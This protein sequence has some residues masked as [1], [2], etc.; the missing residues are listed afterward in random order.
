MIRKAIALTGIAVV[1]AAAFLL[2]PGESK[3]AEAGKGPTIVEIAASNPN[4]STL[5]AAVQEAGLVDTLNGKRQFTV[6]APTNDAFADIGLNAGNI[7]AVP[8]D[9]LRGILLYHVAPGN[10]EAGAVLESD[11]IRTVSGGFLFPVV[12]GSGL[13]IEAE[14]STANVVAADIDASNRVIHVVDAVLL[15]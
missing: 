4:F 11:R 7:A 13:T 15:P 14:N 10:R 5:V 9:V 3:T 12:T 2:A 8:D 6:F 1:A